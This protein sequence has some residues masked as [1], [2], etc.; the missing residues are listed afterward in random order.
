ME[1]FLFTLGCFFL[2]TV[3]M[4]IGVIFKGKCLKGSCGGIQNLMGDCEVCGKKKDP[5]DL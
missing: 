5:S 1:V 4:A 2:V 3:L